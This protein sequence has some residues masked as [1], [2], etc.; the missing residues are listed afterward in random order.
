MPVEN[1]IPQIEISNSNGKE[2]ARP[3]NHPN[4]ARSPQLYHRRKTS[5][6]DATLRT[7]RSGLQ[8]SGAPNEAIKGYPTARHS[9]LE[10]RV[11]KQYPTSSSD[12]GTEADDESGVVL[13]GLPAPPI[14]WRKGLR[15]NEGRGTE[16][17]LLTPSYL[18]DDERRLFIEC[19]LQGNPTLQDSALKDEEILRMRQ[20]FTKR[21]RAELVRRTSETVLLGVV[22]YVA[23]G[24]D[25]MRLRKIMTPGK[26]ILLLSQYLNLRI[27][28]GPKPCGSGLSHLSLIPFQ[29]VLSSYV[30]EKQ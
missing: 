10:L 20:K 30:R 15:E 17:P 24:T 13:K 25:L 6:S 14:R 29:T 16:S 19:Q 7:D 4:L 1:G 8:S 5:I 3:T 26:P 21:R 9:L 2:N 18:D 28:R 12:S 23:C 27:C 22:G 11:K